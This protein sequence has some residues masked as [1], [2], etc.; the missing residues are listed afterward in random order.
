MHGKG[1][2]KEEAQRKGKSDR[3]HAKGGRVGP[4]PR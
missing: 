4:S 3:V 1:G 2:R